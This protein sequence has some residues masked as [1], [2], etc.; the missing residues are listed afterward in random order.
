MLLSWVLLFVAI[1]LTLAIMIAGGFR[2]SLADVK[3]IPVLSGVLGLLMFAL[4]MFPTW[5]AA[6]GIV[7]LATGGITFF[8]VRS[9]NNEK[10]KSKS[11]VRNM[12][13]YARGKITESVLRYLKRMGKIVGAILLCDTVGLSVLLLSKGQW[14][15]SSFT[16]LLTLLLL[17]EGALIGAVGG[18]MFFGYGE[19][20]LFREAAINPM[21][22]RDQIE[23]WRKRRLAQRKWGLAMLVAGFTLIF[24]G[25]LVSILTSL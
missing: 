22:A 14:T 17:L 2:G 1:T 5:I 18:F 4:S 11:E 13:E 9:R 24:L 10:E 19:Y 7:A 21:V 6:V 8:F 12:K 20:S 25:L 16:E 3:I 15:I 23:G